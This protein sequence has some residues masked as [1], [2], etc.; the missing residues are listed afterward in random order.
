[1]S[2]KKLPWNKQFAKD[3]KKYPAPVRPEL[4][5]DIYEN[6]LRE[7][8]E[9]KNN[10]KV[11]ILGSTPEFRDLLL[12]HKITP[13]CCD[14]NPEVFNALKY[15]MQEK[16]EEKFIES[17]W[18][19]FSDKDRFDLIIG[20]CVVNM[21]PPESHCLF[22]KNVA[23]H[24]KK[25]GIFATSIVIRPSEKIDADSGFK[26]NRNNKEK[27]KK[28]LFITAYPD[29][30]LSVGQETG[31]YSPSELADKLRGLN[32]DELI[33]KEELDSM[34]EIVKPS[35]LNIHISTKDEMEKCF[36]NYYLIRDIKY[37]TDKYFDPQYWPIYV[38]NRK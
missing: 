1:M 22:L 24:L 16:G 32:K 26:R 11:L 20:H 9:K 6:I 37:V 38:L 36:N 34:L 19:K 5:M 3:W 2:L 10:P 30:A 12:K 33:N 13:V 7:V 27:S 15:L 18:I 8:L 14:I 31:H 4:E 35:D 25:G 29:L 21:V 23:E 17:D 28:L